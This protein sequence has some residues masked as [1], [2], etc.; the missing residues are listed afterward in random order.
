MSLLKVNPSLDLEKRVEVLE[1]QM[2]EL[3]KQAGRSKDSKDPKTKERV[4]DD[5]EYCCIS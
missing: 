5:D 3:L 2:K 1:K 4:E